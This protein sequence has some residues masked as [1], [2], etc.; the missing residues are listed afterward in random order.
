MKRSI[1]A[2]WPYILP[3]LVIYALFMAIPLV[4]SLRLSLFD[5]PGIGPMTYVGLDNFAKL[6]TVEPWNVRFLNAFRNNVIFFIMMMLLQ[7]LPAFVFA[8][9]LYFGLPGSK[10]FRNVF[11][12]PVTMSVV[13]VGFIARLIF[14]PLWGSFNKLMEGLGLSAL[15]RPWLGEPQTALFI[16]AIVGSW[17]YIGIPLVLFLSGL[18]GIPEELIEAARID[19]ASEFGVL[20]HVLLPLSAPVIGIVSILTFVGNFTAFDLVYAMQ[21]TNAGPSFATD[22][23]GTLFY[24]VAFGATGS[25][26]SQMGLGATIAVCMFAFIG[27]GIVVWLW[28]DRWALRK[29]G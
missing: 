29:L 8:W 19:G 2:L 27:V 18:E 6:F 21:G 28:Y 26:P 20:R 14:N 4:L 12:I 23:F 5:W 17:Q 9:L 25:S 22:I 7:N 16:L 13:M 15:S 1:W 10:F 24:R 3:A 11:F